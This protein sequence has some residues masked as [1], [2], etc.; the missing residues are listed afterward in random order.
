MIE[1]L[2]DRH[3]EHTAVADIPIGKMADL[4]SI[5]EIVAFALRPS[6]VSLNGATLDVNGGRYIR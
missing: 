6:R 1:G 5:A 2:I 4:T 3:S